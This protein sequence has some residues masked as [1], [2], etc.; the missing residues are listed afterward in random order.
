LNK[1]SSRFLFQG[2]TALVTGAASGIGA[3]LADNLANRGC[4]LALIDRDAEGLEAVR[5]SLDSIGVKISTYRLDMANAGKISAF[6]Q[7]F[8]ANH[9]RLHLVFNNAGVS[10]AGSFS[11]L[12]LD[13]MEWLIN[14]NFWGVVRMSKATLPLLMAESDAWII[15]IS[16]ILGIV[17]PAGRSAYCASKFAVRGFSDAL[18]HELADSSVGVSTVYPGGV[19]SNI[20]QNLRLP[21]TRS[22]DDREKIIEDMERN[23][24]TT[25]EKAAEVILKGVERRKARILVGL[26]AKILSVLE[27]L[28]PVR[29]WGLIRKATAV[30]N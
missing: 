18:R 27:R 2:K 12:S 13:E 7:Q 4:D 5:K 6:P 20:Y 30:V 25:V 1:N 11:K 26:D 21:T 22:K 16:S 9:S 19:K 3:A 23:L 10:L 29:Y 8:L 14:I 15:N 28:L 24:H 17:A